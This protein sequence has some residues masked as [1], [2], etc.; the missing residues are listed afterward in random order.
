MKD[1]ITLILCRICNRY[2]QFC[3]DPY[4]VQ[5]WEYCFFLIHFS[6]GVWRCLSSMNSRTSP[7][8]SLCQIL[9]LN[10]MDL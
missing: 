8:P 5:A 6:L 2:S 9:M 7:T 3:I 10:L 1:N 4:I